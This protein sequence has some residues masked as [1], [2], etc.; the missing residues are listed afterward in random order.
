MNAVLYRTD[1]QIA[2]VLE[3]GNA[4]THAAD[5][6]SMGLPYILTPDSIN[7]FTNYVKDGVITA[8]PFK[9]SENHVFNYSTEAWELTNDQAGQINRAI[10]LELLVD[11]DWTQLPDSP[12]TDAKRTEWATY[13]QQLRDLLMT[14]D[15]DST[16]WPTKPS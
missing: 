15:P 16:V 2:A 11:C 6:Q 14:T 3:G 12:L 13:R 7:P 10:R 9:P 4:T 1:G 8:M 5:A